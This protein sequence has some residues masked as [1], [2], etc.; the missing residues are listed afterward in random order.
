MQVYMS[1]WT[2][3]ISFTS[4]HKNVWKLALA[5]AKKHYGQVSL[6]TDDYGYDMMQ[7]LPFD[8]FIVELNN[9]PDYST[10]YTL[11][12]I[13]AY[14]YICSLNEHFLHLDGDVL[15][16]EPLPSS[17]TDQPLFVQSYDY[18]IMEIDA[19]NIYKLHADLNTAVPQDWIDNIGL[20]AYNTGIVGGTNISLINDYCDYVISMVNNPAF[21]KLWSGLP[22]QLSHSTTDNFNSSQTKSLLL[23]QSNLAIFC[24]KLGI[25]PS[26]L[27]DNLENSDN[28]TYK[29]YS[30]LIIN[31]N[32]STILD[33][34]DKRLQS[35]PY[36]LEPR[37]I[38]LD[39]WNTI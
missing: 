37:D 33:R 28:I 7:D 22:G 32:N 25:S 34:I 16:W 3:T 27:F 1:L 21:Y 23:E 29:K 17:V 24:K 6:I 36:N 18:G 2:N 12:K 15:L 10:I 19:Y 4:Q 20:K 5:L 30:H 26:M 35:V 11:G 8:N 14:K 31:K 9:V 38:S 39:D 13:Y